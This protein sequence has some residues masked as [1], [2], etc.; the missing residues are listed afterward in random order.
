VPIG[1]WRAPRGDR[2]THATRSVR[3]TAEFDR[4]VMGLFPGKATL[5]WRA[6]SSHDEECVLGF[7]RS[8]GCREDGRTVLSDEIE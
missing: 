7:P 1:L 5:A 3:R 8:V 4:K 6:L 2:V